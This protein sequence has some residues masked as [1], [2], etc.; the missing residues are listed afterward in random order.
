MRLDV[1]APKENDHFFAPCASLRGQPNPSAMTHMRWRQGHIW[2]GERR[3]HSVVWSLRVGGWKAWLTDG[4][5]NKDA[6]NVERETPTPCG[7]R[8]KAQSERT[9]HLLTPNHAHTQNRQPC[10]SPNALNSPTLTQSNSQRS[11]AH[12]SMLLATFSSQLHHSSLY[13]FTSSPSSLPS[14]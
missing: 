9:T 11:N 3:L 14:A 4:S 2:A 6:G 12:C 5:S 7:D 13:S 8:N 1:G 10:Q